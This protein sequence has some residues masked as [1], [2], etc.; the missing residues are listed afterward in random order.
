M[1]KRNEQPAPSH[2]KHAAHAK[3]APNEPPRVA[4]SHGKTQAIPPVVPAGMKT[5]GVPAPHNGNGFAPEIADAPTLG[6]KPRAARIAGIVLGVVFGVLLVVYLVG[7]AAFSGHFW[8]KA[9]IGSSD[10]SF[11]TPDEVASVLE[12]GINKY[13]LRVHGDGLDVTLSADEAGVRFNAE[14][15]VSDMFAQANEWA[16]PVEV[17]REHDETKSLVATLDKSGVADKLHQAID[18]VNENTE[19][20]VNAT[21]AFD[22][23][24]KMFKIVKEKYGT[25]IN[26]DVVMQDVERAVSTLES[27][28]V[29][30]ERALSQPTIFSDDQ[31][32]I[33]A[34]SQANSMILANVQLMMAGKSA[35]VFDASVIGPCISIREDCSV[36][37]NE[38]ALGAWADEVASAYTTVGSTR[39]YTRADGA[40]FSVSGG[41]YGWKVDRDAL[42]DWA[43]AAIE[44]DQTGEADLP[45]SQTANAWNGVGGRDWGARYIDIDLSAQHACLFDENGEVIWESDIV[46]GKPRG[47]S[48]S[49]TPTGVYVINSN[50]GGS[51]L[52]GTNDDGS[53]YK[54]PV[55]YWMP[56]VGNLIGLH[57]ASWQYAFGGTRYRD[58]AGSHGCVNLPTSK[59][60]ELHGLCSVGDVVVSHW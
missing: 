5:S 57:D 28:V 8:P 25:Q 12:Q 31:R 21:V 20:P 56:F 24:A 45:C 54:T 40:Q 7:V 39:S 33:D 43:K 22:E 36:S 38:D 2:G 32:V 58:G 44:A 34:T 51:T 17:F 10:I 53:K 49:L 1:T 55:T 11:Q 6:S 46:S 50:S 23:D 52:E 13:S 37:L 26:T 3:K 60:A 4:P 48:G 59:A 18:A 19:A 16:W 29:L 47:G 15:I 14:Q 41:S 35:L 27:E 9:T 30:D 42:F